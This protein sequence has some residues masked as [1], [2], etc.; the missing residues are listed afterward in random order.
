MNHQSGWHKQQM[1]M[2]VYYIPVHNTISEIV[3]SCKYILFLGIS[4][5][6]F[7]LSDFIAVKYA[8]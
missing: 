5:L 3:T 2:I 7:I 8:V 4:S 6:F 1:A